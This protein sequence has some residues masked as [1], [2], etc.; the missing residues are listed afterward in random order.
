MF[1]SFFIL[2]FDLLLEAAPSIKKDNNKI[3][4]IDLM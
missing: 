2:L 4:N 1:F 3:K